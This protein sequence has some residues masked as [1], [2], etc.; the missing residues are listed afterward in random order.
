MTV[1]GRV[2]LQQVLMNLMLNGIDA[3]KEMGGMLT[4]KSQL[5]EGGQI[6]ISVNDTGPGLPSGN[7]DRI[8]EAFFTTKPQGSGMGVASNRK[9][10]GFGRTA[11]TGMAR[12]FTLP[13]RRIPRQQTLRS[14]CVTRPS[15]QRHS[16]CEGRAARSK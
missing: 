10:A 7:A 6:E 3:M 11:M 13:F 2:Q 14:H 5:D 16:L 8:F 12:P 1:A 15:G 4:V 9:A